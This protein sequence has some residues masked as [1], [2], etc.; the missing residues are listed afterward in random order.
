MQSWYVKT[1]TVLSKGNHVGKSGIDHFKINLNDLPQINKSKPVC[2]SCPLTMLL[3]TWS[4]IW[5]ITVTATLETD[6]FTFFTSPS[7]S[8][9]LSSSSLPS[10]GMELDLNATPFVL[11]GATT[12]SV[13]R[14]SNGCGVTSVHFRMYTWTQK[15]YAE[16]KHEG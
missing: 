16:Y 15:I 1:T 10:S 4:M 9:L 11:V 8:Q 7:S 14:R 3:Q 6:I 2:F 12:I 5:H 13:D